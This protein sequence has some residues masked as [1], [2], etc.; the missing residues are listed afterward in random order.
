MAKTKKCDRA[1]LSMKKILLIDNCQ[2]LRE[3]TAEILEIENY[4][5][6]TADNGRSGVELAFR[7][8]PDLII[9]DIMMPELD[10]YSVLDKLRSNPVTRDKPFIII[11]AKVG[12]DEF[13]KGMELGA[14][15]FITKPFTALELLCAVEARFKKFKP[16]NEQFAEQKNDIS[17][18]IKMNDADQALI[19]LINSY[20][21]R[22][23]KEKEV[24]YFADSLPHT[25]YFIKKG[26]IKTFVTNTQGKELVVGLFNKNDFLGF[27]A[28][29]E[30]ANYKG[31]AV[32]MEDAELVEIPPGDFELL[33]NANKKVCAKF[34][35]ILAENVTEKED[36]LVRMA[37][38]SMR[39]KVAD[40]L[41]ALN[42]KYNKENKEDYPIEITRENL[43]SMAGTAMESLRRTLAEF[44]N[45]KLIELDESG[46][47]ILNEKK[48]KTL[49]C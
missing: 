10:G 19:K 45:E 31:T 25:V 30:R 49:K 6:I 21:V 13:R 11:T 43:A 48:L 26:R 39:K 22:D 37:Y 41:L 40:A 44:R 5:V 18:I 34:I 35:R 9:C 20:K 15:D 2:T 12:Y 29:L 32:V 28:L 36:E 14:D 3:N 24:I 38:N 33:L 17:E 42:K 4:D 23:Y 16:R 8:N 7:E 47:I 1:A 46:I 27:R